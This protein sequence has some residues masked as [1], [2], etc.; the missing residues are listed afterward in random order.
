MLE[1][2]A[3]WRVWRRGGLI[4]CGL[5]MLF[6]GWALAVGCQSTA[7]PAPGFEL[8]EPSEGGETSTACGDVEVPAGF[9][10][11]NPDFEP[12]IEPACEHPWSPDGKPV[13]FHTVEESI[14][15]S[16]QWFGAWN[17]SVVRGTGDQPPPGGK[18][19]QWKA[20]NDKNLDSLA[21]R[22]PG[23]PKSQEVREVREPQRGLFWGIGTPFLDDEYTHVFEC[24]P[25]MPIQRL[26]DALGNPKY[27]LG[28]FTWKL[29]N[30]IVTCDHPGV[31]DAIA[32]FI[33]DRE[34]EPFAKPEVLEEIRDAAKRKSKRAEGVP[35]SEL[36]FDY[37]PTFKR[38]YYLE[39]PGKYWETTRILKST[40]RCYEFGGRSC[41][42]G[43]ARE[44][45]HWM[46]DTS[47]PFPN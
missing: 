13:W 1:T 15:T 39:P 2:G 4:S 8:D 11:R 5:G 7:G 36:P 17:R 23:F 26:R 3:T 6:S 32:I 43:P 40:K 41:R 31:E 29:G 47:E 22:I 33:M 10:R 9:K 25:G 34:G 21:D 28:G 44:R 19:F 46:F 38:F 35:E 14:A 12:R 20:W 18:T 42:F 27:W 37:Y 30:G 45:V 16:D 24:T